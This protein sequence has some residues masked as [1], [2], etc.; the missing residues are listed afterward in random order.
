MNG[1]VIEPGDPDNSYLVELIVKGEMPKRGDPLSP[2][3]IEIITAWIEAGAPE[4]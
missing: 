2:D 4:N 1:P 3:Q